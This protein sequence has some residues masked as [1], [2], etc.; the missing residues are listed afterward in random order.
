MPAN[1]YIFPGQKHAGKTSTLIEWKRDKDDVYG[2]FTPVV[3]NKRV[4]MNAATG[5][6]F[7]MEAEVDEKDVFIIGKYRF[8][9]KGFEKAINIIRE[10]VKN[11]SGWLI[12]DEI[13]PLELRGEGFHDVLI[14][15]ISTKTDELKLVLVVREELVQEVNELLARKG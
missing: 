6:Q 11:E 8:S 3:N 12:I 5:E 10:G 2:I 9:K 4:F 14:E 13:G 7:S 15:I 1:V